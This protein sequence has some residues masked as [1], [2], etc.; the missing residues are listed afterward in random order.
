[1]VVLF[2]NSCFGVEGSM[3][4]LRTLWK[5]R[6]SISVTTD[7]AFLDIEAVENSVFKHPP[8]PARA[9]SVC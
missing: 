6:R 9:C 3:K 8:V 2:E 1:V 5:V 7:T 4:R